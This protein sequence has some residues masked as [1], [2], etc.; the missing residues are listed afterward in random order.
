[1]SIFNEL[2]RRNVLKVTIAYIVVAW[3][4]AQVLELIFD[5]FGAP[6]WV[7]K[8]VLVLMAA[9]LAFAIFFAWAYELTPEGI[10]REA[11][12]VRSQSVT[13]QTAKKLNFITLGAIALLIVLL[14]ADHFMPVGDD[15]PG[16]VQT[17]GTTE[18]ALEVVEP[19][20][21]VSTLLAR[22]VAVLPFANLSEDPNNA[23]FAGGV[24]EDILTSLSRIADLR[25]IS[26]TSM[27]KIAEQ[28]LDIREIGLQLNV[29][30][31][32]E[33]SVRRAGDKV[34]VTVQLVDAKNDTHL[35]AENYDRKLDDIF[36]VQSEIA[37]KIAVQ[38]EAELSPEQAQ[39]L[40][41]VPTQN[42]QAYDLYLKARELNRTWLGAEGFR[43]MRPLLEQA[44]ALDPN[45]L[46]A[47]VM[48]AEVYGRLVWT[49]AD[50]DGG[51]REKAKIITD[52]ILQQWPDRPE[53]DIADGNYHYTVEDD[54]QKALFSY[55]KALPFM[56]NDTALLLAIAASY[57]RLNQFALGLPVI[58][59]AES[60]DPEHPSIATE[61]TLLLVGSG[62]YEEAIKH[63]RKAAAKFPDDINAQLY[64][65]RL[66]LVLFGNKSEYL[67]IIES[68][69]NTNPLMIVADSLAMRMQL[70]AEELD[71][72][73]NWMNQSRSEADFWTDIYFD[74][75]IAELLN[76]VDR[77]DESQQ[78]ASTTL[79]SIGDRLA[80]GL[81]LS[82]NHPELDYAWFAYLACLANDAAEFSRYAAMANSITSTLVQLERVKQRWLALA[83][84][85]CG[86]VEALWVN[87]EEYTNDLSGG[88]T[89]WQLALDPLY[90]HY[91]AN[92]P[93]YQEM[94]KNLQNDKDTG[95]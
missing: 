3:L 10:K 46:D 69:K 92:I 75:Q 58:T 63:A 24:H 84:A 81:P 18:P 19:V 30:H 9:G 49:E 82:G 44:V 56:Q 17:V 4:V 86:D 89:K 16:P 94:V 55:Q 62:L 53:S 7:M 57:K 6:D 12:V 21:A 8:T 74:I 1:M 65:G 79:E 14:M 32:L 87:V 77:G 76:L 20:S 41:E 25:V 27:L 29:S 42:T 85:E 45:Y 95:G 48:L 47:Q 36:A 11:D 83:M 67:K 35:W 31:V 78:M 51:Y 93:E 72:Q 80:Q 70:N 40:A 22:G 50:T 68:V 28:G 59:L 39:Q 54:Y 52:R 13:N 66:S 73:I 71:Q 33:G 43:Q 23:F 37:Q 90:Q 64:L 61:R 60:L 5:S 15:E 91:F 88:V 26:R 38:L 2:K 34:R